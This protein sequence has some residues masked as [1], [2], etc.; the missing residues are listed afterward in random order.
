MRKERNYL[1]HVKPV[2]DH[3][4]VAAW[5]GI[6]SRGR[7]R[8]EPGAAGGEAERERA[9]SGK[10]CDGLSLPERQIPGPL[11][12]MWSCSEDKSPYCFL[13]W[14]RIKR[15]WFRRVEGEAHPSGLWLCTTE[16]LY[17]KLMWCFANWD[18]VFSRRWGGSG[19]A[20]QKPRLRQDSFPPSPLWNLQFGCWVKEEREPRP[21][22][23]SPSLEIDHQ[24]TF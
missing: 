24:Y 8:L 5:Q 9:P 14:W 2:W 10:A 13:V 17:L 23:V 19:A 6:I 3:N 22:G 4:S 16:M 11:C 21:P 18:A 12:G 15:G 7:Q 20:G 1:W